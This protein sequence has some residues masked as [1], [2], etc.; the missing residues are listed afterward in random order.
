VAY[1][2]NENLYVE[3]LERL[4]ERDI[5]YAV[6][7][8]WETLFERSLSDLDIVVSPDHLKKLECNLVSNRPNIS[9]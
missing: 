3:I 5:Y 2:Q 8:G 4:D 1:S 7:H 9:L 6:L